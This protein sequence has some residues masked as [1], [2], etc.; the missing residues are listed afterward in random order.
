MRDHEQHTEFTPTHNY[1]IEY[2]ITKQVLSPYRADRKYAIAY[3]PKLTL[4]FQEVRKQPCYLKI[5]RWLIICLGLSF[6]LS[7]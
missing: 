2:I 7:Y 3:F 1:G 4:E 6:R 5:E